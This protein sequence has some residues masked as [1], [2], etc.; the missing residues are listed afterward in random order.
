MTL[1]HPRN[2]GRS[3][4]PRARSVA[5]RAGLVL[6]SAAVG[7][8]CVE[9]GA[10]LLLGP[11]FDA[12]ERVLLVSRPYWRTWGRTL[13]YAPDARVRSVALFGDRI[14]VDVRFRT[15][16]MGLIDARSYAGPS[17]LPRERRWAFVGDSF[18]AG[19]HGGEPWVPRLRER[20]AA[21]GRAVAIY[22]LGVDGAGFPH[23]ASL[24]E[25]TAP[26]LDYG[27]VAVLFISNDFQ[28]ND[29]VP[30]ESGGRISVC[31]PPDAAETW[32]CEPL[33]ILV[34]D[35]RDA[36]A[37]ALR[38]LAR[39]SGLVEP[40]HSLAE[41]VARESFVGAAL[42]RLARPEAPAPELRGTVDLSGWLARIEPVARD[43]EL[44]F[45]QIPERE[46]VAEGAYRL[47]PRASIERAGHRYVSLL[48]SCGL[49]E[50]HYLARDH[51]LDAAGYE[52]LLGCVGSALGLL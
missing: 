23:F 24:L 45:L 21:R 5:V 34:F 47:D 15:N 52:R 11:P 49:R 3:S 31:P 16:E 36:T 50:E 27:R 10:R 17:G 48:D 42:R 8:L 7:W 38:A 28:R 39:A 30:V 32:A 51:H 13:R 29:W 1:D 40:P 41:R 14:E 20:A 12:T 43:R 4:R 19:Y 26:A 33:R 37:P 6:A 46:E 35:D 9:A 22:N 2:P 18:T 25:A 44:T